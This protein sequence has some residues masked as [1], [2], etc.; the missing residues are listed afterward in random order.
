METAIVLSAYLIYRGL[1]GNAVY[2]RDDITV[3]NL[4]TGGWI[5]AIVFAYVIIGTVKAFTG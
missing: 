5:T 4:P 3:T 1:V 2:A